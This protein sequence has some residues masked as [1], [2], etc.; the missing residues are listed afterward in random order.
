MVYRMNNI[1]R[2]TFIATCMVVY[3]VL[4]QNSS[5]EFFD[6]APYGISMPD[7]HGLKWDDPRE[8]HSV[9]VDFDSP[10]QAGSKLR[11]EYW[12]SYWPEQ[13]LPKDRVLGSGYSGWME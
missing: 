7:E 6:A 13:H 1:F 4:G 12:G 3:P 5:T 2:L 11:L 8:I 10:L 9:I